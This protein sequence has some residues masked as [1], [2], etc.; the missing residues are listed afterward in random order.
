MS[1]KLTAD[2]LERA[3]ACTDQVETFRR[4]WPEGGRVT[5]SRCRRAVEAGL[6]VDWAAT[7]LL[8]ALALK[9][10]EDAKAPAWKAYEDAK[11]PAWKAYEDA[12]AIAWKAYQ[13]ARAIAF[14]HAWQLP[15][16]SKP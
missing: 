12:R 3:G 4:L 8:S 2:M 15:E 14:Y 5:L 1:R 11:A 16:E 6:D 7:H 13:D 10:C 9:A